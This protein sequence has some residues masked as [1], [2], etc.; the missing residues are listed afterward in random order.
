[1]IF[2]G[3]QESIIDELL[4]GIK[5]TEIEQRFIKNI[6]KSAGHDVHLYSNEA[7]I[8]GALTADKI[9]LAIE[10]KDEKISAYKANS[11]SNETWLLLVM[12]GVKESS[13]YSDIEDAVL[14]ALFKTSF[15]KL[16]LF[17]F[18]KGEHKLLKTAPAS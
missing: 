14:S 7:H 3:N 5:E 4:S 10:S 1:M 16:Y 15:D 18:F 11:K 2:K 8:V 9:H 12:G 17:D 6:R 13:D